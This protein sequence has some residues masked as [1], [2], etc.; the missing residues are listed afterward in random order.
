MMLRNEKNFV[1]MFISYCTFISEIT[2]VCQ[3][4]YALSNHT[5]LI[6]NSVRL[7]LGWKIYII[8]FIPKYI[9]MYL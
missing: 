2:S 8:Q 3:A 7:K 5:G 4:M 9:Y 6:S 1:G